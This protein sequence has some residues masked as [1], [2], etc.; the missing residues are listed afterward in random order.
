M[1]PSLLLAAVALLLSPLPSLAQSSRYPTDAEI[2]R[3]MQEVRRE[4]PDL[5][6]GEFYGDRRTPAEIRQSGALVERWMD[7]DGAIAP[8]LGSWAAI[9][10]SLEIFPGAEPGQVCILDSAAESAYLYRGHVVNGRLYT[11]RY[12]MVLGLESGFL[13]SMFVYEGQL[14]RYEYNNQRPLRNPVTSDYYTES[15]PELVAQ[16]QQFGCIGQP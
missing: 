5:V 3:L 12:N 2:D 16:F 8:F 4:V 1:R 11:E 15:Y 14:G 6:N 10:E 13:V 9:E 7:V